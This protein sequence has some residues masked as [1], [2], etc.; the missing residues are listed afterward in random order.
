MAAEYCSKGAS[1]K[2][3]DDC[4]RQSWKQRIR[5]GGDG[6]MWGGVRWSEVGCGGVG[7]GGAGL[8]WGEM[9]GWVLCMS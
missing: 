4:K 1:A 7:W 8:G 2:A 9:R 5:A 6:V 3:G